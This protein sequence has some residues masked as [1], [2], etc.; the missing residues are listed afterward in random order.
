MRFD[1]HRHH[2]S[3]RVAKGATLLQ[4]YRCVRENVNAH[5]YT[6]PTHRHVHAHSKAR[7][8]LH[9]H[10]APQPR[11]WLSA[12]SSAGSTRRIT[13]A[14]ERIAHE[15]PAGDGGSRILPAAETHAHLGERPTAAS[16][17]YQF[18]GRSA[19]ACPKTAF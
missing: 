18:A 15:Q 13:R 16:R 11:C 19:F 9:P 17:G 7:R 4:W 8:Q 6:T 2:L 12:E 3:C 10:A 14:A 1:L 5:P